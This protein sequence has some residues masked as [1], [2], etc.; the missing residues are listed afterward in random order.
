MSWGFGNPDRLVRAAEL[1]IAIDVMSG[2]QFLVYGEVK[3]F[4]IEFAGTTAV[5][6]VLVVELD[7]DTEELDSLA[8]LVEQ[9]KGDH[10]LPWEL[11]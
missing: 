3:M 9:V 4:P 11:G 2:E 8:A 1:V 7:F 5:F 6:T 10:D